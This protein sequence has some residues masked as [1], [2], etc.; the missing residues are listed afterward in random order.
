MDKKSILLAITGLFIFLTAFAQQSEDRKEY[1]E[2]KYT[3][4]FPAGRAEIINDYKG[5]GHTLETMINDL[6]QTLASE[7]TVPDSLTIISSTSPEGPAALNERLAIQRAGNTR[8]LLIKSFPQ[9]KA[10]RINV[11]SSVNDWS[12]MVLTLRRDSTFQHG[13]EILKVLL[14]PR[15]ENKDLAIRSKLPDEYNMLKNKMFDNMRTS[16]VTIRVI[17]TIDN[18]DEFVVEEIQDELPAEEPSPVK[19]DKPAMD[20]AVVETV[21]EPIEESVQQEEPSKEKKPYYIAAKTN[22]LYDAAIIPNVGVEVYL[23]K[24]FSVAGNWMYSW[25]KSDRV[26]WYWRTYGGDLALRYW[27]GRAAK[28]KPLTGHHIGLYG[29]IL[30]YDIEVGGRGYLGD[31][32]SYGGG[33][34]YGYSLPVRQRLNIDFTLGLGYLGG[35]FQEYLP[36]DGHYV[37]QATKKRQYIGPTKAEISL[38]WLIGHGN[39]NVNKKK[40]R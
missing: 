18:V 10:D 19:E 23:G 24:N 2:K 15:I 11:T 26:S 16:S 30:T 31:R 28:E 12:G 8:N 7:G 22:L 13:V 33:L 35:E 27:L 1:I 9:F 5:N 3:F 34:E 25:W 6:N 40:N 21:Q 32:W 39:W 38:V 14:D 17:K 4:F 36:I 29:Q 20:T 37:W